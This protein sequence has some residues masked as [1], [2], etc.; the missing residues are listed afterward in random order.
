MKVQ[1]RTKKEN[2]DI[3][4]LNRTAALLESRGMS[5]GKELTNQSINQTQ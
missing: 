2:K 5:L 1:K 4:A 3:S